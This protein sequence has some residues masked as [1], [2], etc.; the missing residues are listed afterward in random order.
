MPS[1][2]PVMDLRKIESVVWSFFHPRFLTLLDPITLHRAVYNPNDRLYVYI[3]EGF[4]TPSL[5][6]RLPHKQ[7]KSNH[8]VNI[9]LQR[10]MG[11]KES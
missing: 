6:H 10:E 3:C 2:I 8:N 4:V 11:S 5:Q 1:I 7:T 9:C